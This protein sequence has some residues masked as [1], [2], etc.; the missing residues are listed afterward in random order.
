MSHLFILCRLYKWWG[1]WDISNLVSRQVAPADCT[2]ILTCGVLLSQLIVGLSPPMANWT[3][4]SHG[5]P[6]VR[7][8]VNSKI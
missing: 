4:W 1:R 8:L 7:G 3:C 2:V 6:Y 5:D